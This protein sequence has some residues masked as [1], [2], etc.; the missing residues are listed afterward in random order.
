MIAE[1]KALDPKPGLAFSGE[2][3]PAVIP[4]VLLRRLPAGG[5]E[6]AGGNS[7][8][9]GDW[10]VE[11]NPDTLPAVL[12][13]RRYY[14]AVSK[15]AREK[16]EKEYLAEKMQ[17]ASWL[18]RS[19]HQRAT[20]ILRVANE[21]VLQQDAFFRNGI[22]GLK[23]LILRDVAAAIGMHESTISRVTNAKFIATP[24]RRV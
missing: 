21:I 22:S 10:V 12:V 23:P 6:A 20:T 19:L 18:V 4:D 17:A 7:T 14:T 8:Q 24:A 16:S 9:A 13:N 15:A 3:P 2:P 11:L 1:I 5:H